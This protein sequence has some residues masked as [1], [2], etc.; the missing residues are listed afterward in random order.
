M[1]KFICITLIFINLLIPVCA[2]G[3]FII[4][5]IEA[6]SDTGIVTIPLTM[7]DIPN[8]VS[9][10]VVVFRPNVNPSDIEAGN[11][12]AKSGIS[13]MLVKTK[14]SDSMTFSYPM[15]D[16][17]PS[18][19]YQ[20]Q[21]LVDNSI[22]KTASF[23]YYSAAEAVSALALVKNPTGS[24]ADTYNTVKDVLSLDTA[25]YDSLSD[26]GIYKQKALTAFLNKEYADVGAAKA[27]FKAAVSV[28]AMNKAST[29]DEISSVINHAND[30]IGLKNSSDSIFS[31][32]LSA[33][34]KQFVLQK[35]V[36]A[37]N[38]NTA[39]DINSYF[40][41]WVLFQEIV[42]VS[43]YGLLYDL[44][45]TN[46]LKLGGINYSIYNLV[47]DKNNVA[48][49]FLRTKAPTLTSLSGVKAAFEACASDQYNKENSGG[50]SSGGGSPSKGGGGTVLG[51]ISKD[52]PELIDTGNKN[53]QKPSYEV[54]FDDLDSVLWAEEAILSLASYGIISGRGENKFAPDDNITREDFVKILTTALDL[55]HD[56]SSC[57]FTDVNPD[58]YF[59]KNVASASVSG[60]IK[61][62]SETEFGTKMNVTRQD[63]ATICTRAAEK[64]GGELP[65]M[66]EAIEFLDNAQISDYAKQSIIAMQRSGII[67]G[68]GDN[69]FYPNDFA[70]RAEAAKIIY[71]LCT[72]LGLI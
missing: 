28:S 37:A 9:V 51:S 71:S 11:I 52:T 2:S 65:M 54:N 66:Y 61:G 63:I 40:D 67:N 56:D 49:E 44:L 15:N 5:D 32:K 48:I 20:V 57:S 42:T 14:K 62:V 35:L 30:V 55:V 22:I 38:F 16:S 26:S 29:I 18:G 47:N 34:A 33:P 60:I 58:D 72:L 17:D 53:T 27:A 6:D 50:S 69:M 23:S 70:T 19:I 4:G 13:N 64:L 45:L 59:Y 1:K 39:A 24:Q 25:F 12:T 36:T 8:D 7:T 68:R 10:M 43:S 3:D 46:D 21:I 41:E 31:Q